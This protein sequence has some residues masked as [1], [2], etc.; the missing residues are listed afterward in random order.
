MHF[1]MGGLRYSSAW[2]YRANILT[3]INAPG[4]TEG[5][6]AW[7]FSARYYFHLCQ[8]IRKSLGSGVRLFAS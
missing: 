8:G 5:W 7:L 6:F 2:P 1:S 3:R 4:L